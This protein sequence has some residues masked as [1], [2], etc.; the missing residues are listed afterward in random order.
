MKTAA[1]I[2]LAALCVFPQ[3]ARAEMFSEEVEES[4]M[5]EG[6]STGAPMTEDGNRF[7]EVE[8]Y[9]SSDS[10]FS[11]DTR[12]RLRNVNPRGSSVL[13]AP[14]E[15]GE[16]SYLYQRTRL[17]GGSH[18]QAGWLMR[19]PSAG[20]PLAVESI[21]DRRMAKSSIEISRVGPLENLV[22]GNYTL[23]YGQ[24]LLFY[25]G[26]GELIRPVKVKAA[27]AEPDFTSSFNS[28]LRGAALKM[29]R[30]PFGVSFF[31]SDKPLDLRVDPVT[32]RVTQ[33]LDSLRAFT[34]DGYVAEGK[35]IVA[36][37]ERMVGARAELRMGDQR[38][39]VTAYGS[40]YGRAIDPPNHAFAAA[41][42]FRGDRN[43]MAGFDWDL[44]KGLLNFFGEAGMAR[45]G[46]EGSDGKVSRAFT[47]TPSLDLNPWKMWMSLYD[48]DPDFFTRHG[49]GVSFTADTTRNQRGGSA[50]LQYG[51]ERFD[52]EAN[53]GTAAFPE[54]LGDGGGSQPVAASSGREIFLRGTWALTRELSLTLRTFIT[55]ED[56]LDS[57]VSDGVFQSMRQRTTRNR[58]E[59]SWRTPAAGLRLRYETRAED[60]L[61]TGARAI[62]RL[63]MSDAYYRPTDDLTIKAR[64]YAFDSPDAYL[65][66]GVEEIWDGVIYNRLAGAMNELRG[67]PGTRFYLIVEQ[68]VGKSW[69]LWMKYD[70]NRRTSD[71]LSPDPSRVD[72]ERSSFGAVRQGFHLQLDCRWGNS[73]K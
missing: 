24:G 15:A 72:K 18:V 53:Y 43:D 31:S 17:R 47:A 25:D 69:N 59:I 4:D 50:G 61:G 71:F 67:P 70:I 40:R 68:K 66:T 1:I 6:S 21:S 51:G 57:L 35:N 65:T 10:I 36:V 16:N 49:Q 23:S 63:L 30:G 64:F 29:R 28:Y 38:V 34:G 37:H 41:R 12:L 22:V 33:D 48:Y 46:G 7:E 44:Y 19:R 14:P 27:G 3:T 8:E 55:E 73:G 5:D 11:G 60:N 39:G 54:S 42:N 13:S 62:G 26:L 52:G 2:F 45:P 58:G 56:R 32:G 20:P 9:R